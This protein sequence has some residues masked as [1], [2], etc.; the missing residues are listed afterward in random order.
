MKAVIQ[1]GGKQYIVSE[2]DKLHIEKI[3]TEEGKTVTFNE[4]LLVADDKGENVKVGTPTVDKATVEAV[5]LEH[6][7][8]KKVIVGKYKAKK[9][10]RVKK[11]HRQHF[12][13][14]QVKKING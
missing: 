13:E 5:V 4:V 11:G 6:G 8:H 14:V 7:R 2:D 9:R 1:T 10:Y 12:T 3:E